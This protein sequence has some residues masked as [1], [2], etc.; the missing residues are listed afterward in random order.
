MRVRTEASIA[1]KMDHLRGAEV[2]MIAREAAIGRQECGP[3][4]MCGVEHALRIDEAAREVAG[5]AVT[6]PRQGR[7][8]GLYASMSYRTGRRTALTTA[9]PSL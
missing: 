7:L 6:P 4:L 5:R 8:E 1:G 3:V 2:H 9:R